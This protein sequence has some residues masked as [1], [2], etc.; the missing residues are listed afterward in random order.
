MPSVNYIYFFGY[1]LTLDPKRML[2]FIKG[3]KYKHI[4]RLQEF[5]DT[6]PCVDYRPYVLEDYRIFYAQRSTDFKNTGVPFL[7]YAPGFKVY[8]ILYLITREQLEDLQVRLDASNFWYGKTIALGT[9][10]DQQIKSLSCKIAYLKG[11]KPSKKLQ[12]MMKLNLTKFF[13]ELKPKEIDDYLLDAYNNYIVLAKD[14]VE[15]VENVVLPEVETTETVETVES[16]AVEEN[17]VVEEEVKVDAI[18]EEQKKLDQEQEEAKSKLENL[19][20]V[21]SDLL[22]SKVHTKIDNNDDESK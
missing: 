19:G 11:N 2:T 17:A 10:N 12:E 6:T 20:P 9:F 3:K 16:V 5:R 22:S 7:E 21:E 4:R 13:P 15:E 8:G 14:K 18:V 1:G